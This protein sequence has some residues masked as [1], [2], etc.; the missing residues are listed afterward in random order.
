MILPST[1]SCFVSLASSRARYSRSVKALGAAELIARV[2][3][4]PF[5]PSRERRRS[6]EVGEELGV[7]ELGVS[8]FSRTSSM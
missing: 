6:L 7:H 3:P 1:N 2:Y 5:A 8:G 4:P